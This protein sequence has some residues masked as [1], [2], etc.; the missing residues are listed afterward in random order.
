MSP[1]RLAFYW[2]FNCPAEQ[3]RTED[4]D[5]YIVDPLNLLLA[6]T[7]LGGDTDDDD[8]DEED[9]LDFPFYLSVEYN[10]WFFFFFMPKT[11]KLSPKEQMSW[12]SVTMDE[13][14]NYT[15]ANPKC[16]LLQ[17]M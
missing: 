9:S 8:D 5:D 2:L 7:L 13:Y 6:L 4:D 12:T 1:F 10:L 15:V 11:S 17:A 3:H 14:S 16:Y